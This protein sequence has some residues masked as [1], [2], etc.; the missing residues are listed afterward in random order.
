MNK[1]LL[2]TLYE[3]PVYPQL[4]EEV[5]KARPVLPS[6]DWK[7]DNINEIKAK[8][9]EQKGFDLVMSIITIGENR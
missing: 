5:K 4:L 1:A 9:C 3:N 6:Y 8:L 2:A 7:T